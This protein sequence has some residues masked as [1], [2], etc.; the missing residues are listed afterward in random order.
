MDGGSGPYP[1]NM[2]VSLMLGPQVQRCIVCIHRAIPRAVALK[3]GIAPGEQHLW[4]SA[5]YTIDAQK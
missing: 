1:F 2:A 5:W 4:L 3:Q